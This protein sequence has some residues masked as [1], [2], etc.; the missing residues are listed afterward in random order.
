MWQSK[1]HD[2]RAMWKIGKHKSRLHVNIGFV[3]VVAFQASQQ[4]NQWV[5]SECFKTKGNWLHQDRSRR[6]GWGMCRGDV[7]HLTWTH[8]RSESLQSSQTFAETWP[9]NE[10]MNHS[11]A[12][13]SA[14]L[15]LND[16][17]SICP[18]HNPSANQHPEVPSS[19][20]LQRGLLQGWMFLFIW[21]VRFLLGRSTA[22]RHEKWTCSKGPE[23]RLCI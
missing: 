14:K 10:S 12:G 4:V 5:P 15:F 18:C 8:D 17:N 3:A 16:H 9:S 21:Q 22:N 6:F 2:A 13:A 11:G 1:M 19:C 23:G 7:E 20:V